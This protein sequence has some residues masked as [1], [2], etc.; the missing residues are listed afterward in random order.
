LG[1]AKLGEARLE[2][3]PTASGMHVEQLRALSSS[4]QINASGDW[5]GSPSNSHTHLKIGFASDDL[6]T[7]LGAF[8][9]EGM[10][11]GGKTND[12]LDASWPGA[13]SALSLANMNGTL[14]IQV[15]NG[16]I[17]EATTPMKGRLLG[18]VSL[19]ELPRRL[20]L[21]FGDVFGKGLAFD[22]ITGDFHLADG[23]ATTTNLFMKGPAANISITGRTGLRAKDFD[24]Q[25]QVMPH[26]GNS[27]PLVGAVVGGPI[28][29]AA[30]FAV[31][32]LFG[33]RF[34]KAASARYQ[35]S[36]SWDKPVMTLIEKREIDAPPVAPLLNPAGSLPGAAGS[37]IP[38]TSRSSSR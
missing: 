23:N 34:S 19:F 24:Q 16:H 30:G 38:A 36:G 1:D 27:L 6:G 13:P 3:W 8:G 17:P 2:T 37:A 33:G 11:N 20:S 29:A 9:F 15:R 12:Q 32:G 31:Q 21:D 4:V 7:M 25:V 5:N 22:S 10:V 26:V 28:G 14:T 35:I 18:L